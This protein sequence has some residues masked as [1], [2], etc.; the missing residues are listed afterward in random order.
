MCGI[1][2]IA[3]RN[4]VRDEALLG[5][6]MGRIAHRGPDAEGRWEDR[7]SGIALGHRRL[8]IIDLSERGRQPMMN[9]DGRIQMICN[10]EIYNYL[11]LRAE[12]QK[13]GHQFR[14][15][16]DSE[17]IV[18]AYEAWGRDCFSHFNGMFAIALW[19]V[20][21]KTLFLA[22]D[23]L[24][25]KPLLYLQNEAG[26]FFSSEAKSFLEMPPSIWAPA[27]D[28]ATLEH[29]LTFQFLTD[30]AQCLLR[31]VKKVRPGHVVT[32]CGGTLQESAFWTLRKREDVAALS[33]PEAVAECEAKLLQSV[34][35]QMQ[36]D[37]PV[38]ILLSGGLDSSLVAALA[39][40]KT[41]QPVH[42]FTAGFEHRWD[43][44]PHAAAVARHIG[45]DHHEILINPREISDRIEDL[46][47][48]YDDLSS[49]DG[50][51]FTTIL[52]TDQIKKLGIKVLL[53]GEG[54]DEAF[55][56]YS[57]YGLSCRPYRWLP[58][59]VRAELFNYTLSRLLPVSRP[60]RKMADRVSHIL[61]GAGESDICRQ[62]HRFDL[63][64]E[65][66]QHFLMKVDH[67]TMANSIE[68]RVPYL[69]VDVVEFAYSLP[70]SYKFEGEWF[71]FHAVQ[72]K[73]VLRDVGRRYLPDSIWTRKKRGFS[74]PVP[75]MLQSNMD[76][77]RGYLLNPSSLARSLY[78]ARELER[79][80]SF[81][82]TFYSPLEKDK[83]F[84]V[85]KLFL[86]EVW[87]RHYLQSGPRP[88]TG[89]VG[90]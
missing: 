26:L 9:E 57:W 24:G 2:G 14:S 59:R 70:A 16:C 63:L 50:G 51:L 15:D 34:A 68:A 65:L 74:I 27:M 73:R 80:L 23:H 84:M 61:N 62:L 89:A 7:A 88:E 4:G 29:L 12:L 86:L 36:A 21:R 37:V 90:P 17:I 32:L 41:N 45:S 19:D 20:D 8:S 83:E 72:E 30:P 67:G 10:G 42:T 5:R 60:R 85:W 44:R 54:A 11:A 1:A 47:Y 33:Y 76:K 49:F 25:V 31:G 71:R 6:M 55:A 43:E 81:R 78:S 3:W 64:H 46:I 40:R 28:E 79:L 53:V 38:G 52:L 56:G 87:R 48:Y 13:L 58:G 22:R 18:H 69:D 39:T 66:P 82:A 35:L 77:V 75:E